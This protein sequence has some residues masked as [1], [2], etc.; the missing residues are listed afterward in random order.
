MNSSSADVRM[1]SVDD[2]LVHL[3]E[4]LR[5]LS[6]DELIELS[7]VSK[8]YFEENISIMPF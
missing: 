6:K 1:D 3:E 5:R 2:E 7:T 8:I 4:R